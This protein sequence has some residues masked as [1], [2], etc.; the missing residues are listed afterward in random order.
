MIDREHLAAG[1][2]LRQARETLGVSQEDFGEAIGLTQAGVSKCE[3]GR[4]P[5]RKLVL[6]AIE[7]VYGISGEWLQ[8]GKGSMELAKG[9][10]GTLE[11]AARLSPE[12]LAVWQRI[13]R[14]LAQQDGDTG[15][16][17]KKR[18]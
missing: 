14:C 18:R 6:L 5:L 12:N 10:A 8:T 2:R 1:E 17:G 15:S 16:K 4:I 7:H 9:D 11:V 13:G 3:A